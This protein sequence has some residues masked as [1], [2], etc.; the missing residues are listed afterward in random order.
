MTRTRSYAVL[1]GA[2]GLA[3][4]RAD[5]ESLE[6]AG[7]DHIFQTWEHADLWQR[8]VGKGSKAKPMLVT[9]REDGRLVGVFPA[10]RIRE[11][12]LPLVT[13]LGAP[14]ALDYGDVVFDG[15]AAETS[16][17]EF[18]SESLRQLSRAARTSVL[19]LPNVRGDARARDALG[20]RMR[21]L[22]ESTAPFL[23]ITGTWEEYLATRG[24]DLRYELKR[25]TK[26]L[27]EAGDS[28]FELLAPG[29]ER[30]AEAVAALAGFQRSRF[31]ALGTR[32]SLFDEDFARFRE[33]QATTDPHSR[34]ATLRL[35]G[36]IIAVSLHAVYRGRLYCFAPGFDN[37]F[38]PFSPGVL[39]RGFVIRSC[40][41]N[42]WDPCDFGWGDEAYKYRWTDQAATLTT[43]VGRGPV[44]SAF[45]AGMGMRRA[46][47]GALARKRD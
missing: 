7:A 17:D 3:A 35:N 28:V 43:F 11:S 23:P 37:R 10:C 46:L 20:A 38:A 25:R 12:G 27:E 15:T 1:E 21:V 41:E 30:V 36:E 33:L 8:T 47:V 19:Y 39:L 2:E 16:L 44:G 32:T 9:L 4:L 6:A 24:K 18:V 26:R 40:Y 45:A 34:V 5:W 42:G 13:W 29:D 22:R 14:R 31:D